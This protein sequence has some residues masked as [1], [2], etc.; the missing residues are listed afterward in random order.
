M[1]E[2]GGL[3]ALIARI[4]SLRDPFEDG[5]ESRVAILAIRLGAKIGL[6]APELLTLSIAAGLHDIGKLVISEHMLNTPRL[7][8]VE[9]TLVRNH[10]IFGETI[11]AALGLTDRDV[12]KI[13]RQHHENWNGTGYPDHVSKQDIHPLA[14]VLRICDSFDAMTSERTYRKAMSHQI[15]MDEVAKFAGIW[16]DSDYAILF[17]RMMNEMMNE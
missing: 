12:S 7:S 16:Y 8:I 11:I 10:P 15:A 1:I 13:V 5:H 4:A 2:L 14:R 17:M 9:M 6:S 3:F